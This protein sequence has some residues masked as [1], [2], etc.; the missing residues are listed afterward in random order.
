MSTQP[1]LATDDIT[2]TP[3]SSE[4][5]PLL[6]NR[7]QAEVVASEEEVREHFERQK[8]EADKKQRRWRLVWKSAIGAVVT[9]FGVV[10]IVGFIK[11]GDTGFDWKETFKKAL[12]GGLSGAA[13]KFPSKIYDQEPLLI[14]YI[15]MV[16]QVLTLMVKLTV[17][18]LGSL[19]H[20]LAF[21]H[22]NE[23]PIPIWN[24]PKR[25]REDSLR[26]WW[27][28]TILF[29]PSSCSDPRPGLKVPMSY[30]HRR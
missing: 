17:C 26:R 7:E 3:S 16:L 6:S 12:G 4:R 24:I 2:K 25:R 20:S 14:L 19:T 10:F 21:T 22:N 30:L 5:V 13:G 28:S 29:R 18:Y 27:L 15:A 1:T 11:G 9:V 8:A 23:L